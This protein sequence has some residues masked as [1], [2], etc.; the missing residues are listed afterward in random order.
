[1]F[2]KIKTDW[3]N[4]SALGA[5]GVVSIGYVLFD[6]TFAETHFQFAF[7][8]FPVFISEFLL[9]FCFFLFV[10]RILVQS[11]GFNKWSLLISGYFCFVLFKAF[12]GYLEWGPHALRNAALMYYPVFAVF[13]Y[14]FFQKKYFTAWTNTL[15]VVIILLIFLNK[16]YYVYYTLSLF[17]LATVLLS[18]L[19]NRLVRLCLGGVLLVVMPYIYLCVTA[20]MMILAHLIFAGYIIAMGY[21]FLTWPHVLKLSIGGVCLV[22][23]GFGMTKFAGTERLRS[24]FEYK[25]LIKIYQEFENRIEEQRG[26]FMLSDIKPGVYNPND[27]VE[28]NYR[29]DWQKSEGIIN[30]Y[31]KNDDQLVDVIEFNGHNQN[32]LFKANANNAVFRLFIWRDMFTELRKYRPVFG[33]SFG[34]PLRSVSLEILNWGKSEWGRDGWVAAHNSFFHMI[35]RAGMVGIVFIFSILA[36]LFIMIKGFLRIRSVPGILLCGLILSWFVAANF[37]IVLEIPYTAIPIWSLYG[38]TFAYYHSKIH[39]QPEKV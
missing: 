29:I 26:D 2:D 1:M 25:S 10:L 31:Q 38:M 6:S 14:T 4:L 9:M 22:L 37:L 35:Y 11:S 30:R 17:I 8:N 3:V 34:K 33:F 13:G 15:L 24:I 18:R 16:Q 21:F 39:I 12:C 20:R 32:E 36:V 7:L 5:I 23:I 28:K 19:R 27:P